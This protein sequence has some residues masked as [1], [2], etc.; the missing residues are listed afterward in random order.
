MPKI[1]VCG[2]RVKDGFKLCYTCAKE[3]AK[4]ENRMCDCGKFKKPEFDKC[5]ACSQLGKG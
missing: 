2:K 5:Y 3:K 1:C 4:R